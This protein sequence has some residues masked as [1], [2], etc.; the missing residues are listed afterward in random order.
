MDP[1]GPR[2]TAPL[3]PQD[4][5]L[6]FANFWILH[7]CSPFFKSWSPQYGIDVCDN[8]GIFFGVYIASTE[9]YLQKKMRCG[10]IY[11]SGLS[12]Q[13][14]Q[15]GTQELSPRH[16]NPTL[17]FR[18]GLKHKTELLQRRKNHIACFVLIGKNT[19]AKVETSLDTVGILEE[20]KSWSG[21]ATVGL[22]LGN[23]TIIYLSAR[24]C[25]VIYKVF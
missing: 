20:I 9:N 11:I 14:S 18:I 23:H 24:R 4:C 16:S 12:Q 22:D 1:R 19:N 8:G 13:M 3:C 7:P 21:L 25:N 2:D 10:V 15:L 6:L 17:P 5:L